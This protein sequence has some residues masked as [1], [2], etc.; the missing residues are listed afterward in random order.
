MWF[1]YQP[2]MSS[3]RLA[4]G[5][6]DCPTSAWRQYGTAGEINNRGQVVGQSDLPGD[7]THHAFLWQ[8]GVMTDLGT[9]PGIPGSLANGINNKGQV[10]GFSD[11]FSGNT[12]ALLWQN[13]VMTDLNTLIP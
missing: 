10:V 4:K 6:H 2:H 7:T 8:N 3:V 1:R 5:C 13:G 11:D 9:L 12:V